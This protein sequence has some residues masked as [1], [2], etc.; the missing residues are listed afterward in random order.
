MRKIFNQIFKFV[1]VGVSAAIVD[2]LTLYFLKEYINF[3]VQ[4]SSFSAYILS[5]VFNYFFSTKWVFVNKDSREIQ[6]IFV[7]VFFSVLGLA[8]NQV[9]MLI[10]ELF[11]IY[12]LL[13]KFITT[14]FIM[15]F[16][17]VSRKV[18]LENIKFKIFLKKDEV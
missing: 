6:K 13:S 4:L 10:G 1:V 12:Y 8:L 9:L 7:F 15:I 18:F 14:F 17:F 3:S 11:D 2:F 16:N 5:S